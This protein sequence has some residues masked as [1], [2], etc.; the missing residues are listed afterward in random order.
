MNN[1][2]KRATYHIITDDSIKWTIRPIYAIISMF[3]YYYVESMRRL[4]IKS[5]Y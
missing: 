1:N 2:R 5:R 4:S 3:I